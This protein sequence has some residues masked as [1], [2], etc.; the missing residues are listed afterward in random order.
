MAASAGIVQHSLSLKKDVYML[1]SVVLLSGFLWLGM[2]MAMGLELKVQKVTDRIYA[3]AGPIDGRSHENHALNCTM[4]FIVT[5]K[6]VVLIDS[7]ASSQGARLVEQ[8]ISKVTARKVKWVVNTGAQDHRWLGNGYFAG[9][10]ARIIALQRTVDRQREYAAQ[11]M[12]R[13]KAILKE[14]LE[15]T[16][17]HYAPE[18]PGGDRVRLEMGGVKIEIIWPGGGH[19]PDDAIVWVPEERTVFAGDLVFMDRM[20]GVLED[21]AS[22]VRSWASA[23]KVMAALEPAHVVPG[24]GMPGDLAKARRDTGDYLDW[25]IHNTEPAV[26]E[27]EEIGTLVERLSDAPFHHLKH[28]DS[29]HRKN[30]IRTYLQLEIE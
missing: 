15:G 2:S 5:D 13:L 7:G 28:Y 14:R 27:M 18:P 24:H 25:L 20:L 29:W 4:G 1:K 8:A 21:G 6:G 17:P 23:F 26:S 12:R 22:I 10:G 11:H 9:K 3:L 30:V 19:F 16:V